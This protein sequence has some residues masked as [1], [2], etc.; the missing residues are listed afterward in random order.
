MASL[1]IAVQV[2]AGFAVGSV[3]SQRRAETGRSLE[4]VEAV[5]VKQ[6]LMPTGL[7]RDLGHN[8]VLR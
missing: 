2:I 5:G 3:N 4:Y 1:Q 8:P 7:Q 6:K